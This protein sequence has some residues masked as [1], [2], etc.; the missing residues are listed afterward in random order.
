MQMFLQVFIVCDDFVIEGE[1]LIDQNH[2]FGNKSA[3]FCCLFA[4]T[5]KRCQNIAVLLQR[6][7][8]T[9]YKS[10]ENRL[11]NEDLFAYMEFFP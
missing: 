1:F 8:K 6:K 10:F 9:K 5:D 4:S 7:M 11:Q 3:V 2:N